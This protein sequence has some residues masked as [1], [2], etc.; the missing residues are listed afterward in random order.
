MS[1]AADSILVEQS[2]GFAVAAANQSSVLPF[3][4]NFSTVNLEIV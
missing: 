3:I 4:S 1:G 2:R